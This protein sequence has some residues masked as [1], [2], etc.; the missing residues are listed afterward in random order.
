ME[1]IGQALAPH[2]S[3]DDRTTQKDS[4]QF[5][6]ASVLNILRLIL[7]GSPL[8]DV[9]AIIA[10][11]VE[12]RGDG[13]LCTI[14]LPEGDGKRIYCATSPWIPGF[15][16]QVGSMPIGPKAGSCGTAIYRR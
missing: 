3:S 12:S 5:S 16:E 14:W 2:V 6:S 9:L 4:G 1:T 11:L 10:R 8:P 15:R 13:T 7:A